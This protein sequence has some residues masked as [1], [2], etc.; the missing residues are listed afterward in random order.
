[1]VTTLDVDPTLVGQA[2]ALY[3]NADNVV[4]VHADG[5]SA[6]DS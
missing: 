4:A 5:R 1:M 6:A 2:A 3:R